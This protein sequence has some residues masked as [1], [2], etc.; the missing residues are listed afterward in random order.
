MK[1]KF[2]L[3]VALH[4]AVYAASFTELVKASDDRFETS[5]LIRKSSSFTDDVLSNLREISP[6]VM[7]VNTFELNEKRFGLLLACLIGKV[8]EAKPGMKVVVLSSYIWA[9]E[10]LPVRLHYA[11]L[12]R[13]PNMM[14]DGLLEEIYQKWGSDEK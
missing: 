14:I 3:L 6:D 1:K 5:A 7:I 8:K 4:D 9:K 10:Y 11:D 2:K 12:A 13:D